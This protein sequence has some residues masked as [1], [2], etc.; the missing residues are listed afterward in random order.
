MHKPKGQDKI[1]MFYKIL[2]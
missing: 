1:F 2:I